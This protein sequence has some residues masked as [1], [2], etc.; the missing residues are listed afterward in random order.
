MVVPLKK[1]KN[2][3]SFKNP[4]SRRRVFGW[5]FLKS[6]ISK[7]KQGDE[8]NEPNTGEI[9]YNC[10][11]IEAMFAASNGEDVTAQVDHGLRYERSKPGLKGIICRSAKE[12]IQGALSFFF[13]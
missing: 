3:E 13:E 9:Q 10:G 7:L 8:E 2:C 12:L 4:E 1:R 11:V 5:G 6:L